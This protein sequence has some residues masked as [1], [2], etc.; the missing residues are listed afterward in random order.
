MYELHC[1][2]TASADHRVT[3]LAFVTF[4]A[5]MSSARSSAA[6]GMRVSAPA[7]TIAALPGV[8]CCVAV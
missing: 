2:G 8:S 5:A 1:G 6:D 7:A 3:H 4:L